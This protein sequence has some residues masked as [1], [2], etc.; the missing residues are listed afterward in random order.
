MKIK[1]PLRRVGFHLLCWVATLA[2]AGGYPRIVAFGH[3]LGRLDRALRPGLR[4]RTEQQFRTLAQRLH[5]A[6]LVADHKAII[7]QAYQHNSRAILE[8]MALY[9]ASRP[10]DT[11]QPSIQFQNLESLSEAQKQHQG[12]IILGLHMGNGLAMASALTQSLGPIHVV[13]RESNKVSPGFYR[14]GIEQLGLGAINAATQDG[15]FREMLRALK[16][17]Q[18]VMILMDQGRKQGGVC[19]SFLGKRMGM[20]QGPAELAKRSGAPIVPVFLSE[21]DERGWTFECQPPIMAVAD[22]DAQGTV[23]TLTETMEAHI[24][25]KPHLWSWHQR[26]WV[27]YPFEPTT[28]GLH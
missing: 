12:V 25:K 16:R 2:S 19:V 9:C 23:H 8:V 20:P 15:G 21:V 1:R 5:K 22:S 6:E 18:C 10:R 26:R 3:V 4:H 7:K 27:K 24:L 11:I 17:Q 13:Y 14:R 28:I